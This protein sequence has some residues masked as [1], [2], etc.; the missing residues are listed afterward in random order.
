MHWILEK[1]NHF[2]CVSFYLS[3]WNVCDKQWLNCLEVSVVGKSFQNYELYF[4]FDSQ[5]KFK[6]FLG[7]VPS[8]WG[9]PCVYGKKQHY[10][11]AI[12]NFMEIFGSCRHW[13]WLWIIWLALKDLQW[14]WGLFSGMFSKYNSL[15]NLN[16]GSNKLSSTNM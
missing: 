16:Y 8:Y 15:D 5:V 3:F 2:I 1:V 13:P 6:R 11:K 7:S 12:A 4:L 10:S 9:F 14:I